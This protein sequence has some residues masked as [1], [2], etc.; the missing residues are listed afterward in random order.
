MA[1]LGP[2]S[3]AGW[4][5]FIGATPTVPSGL[6]LSSGHIDVVAP[7]TGAYDRVTYDGSNPVLVDVTG[8]PLG[9]FDLAVPY[10]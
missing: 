5:M 10:P 9:A 2:Q 7:A 4:Q 3:G 1:P 8:D 6:L